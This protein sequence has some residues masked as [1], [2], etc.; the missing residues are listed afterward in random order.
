[1]Y[2]DPLWKVLEDEKHKINLWDATKKAGLD[3]DAVRADVVDILT[4]FTKKWEW[5]GKASLTKR[6]FQRKIKELANTELFY[7]VMLLHKCRE[8]PPDNPGKG[9]GLPY[10]FEKLEEVR[11]M[12][13]NHPNFKDLVEARNGKFS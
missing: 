7:K 8:T 6:G 1:M 4:E 5:V 9:G 10:F 11:Y 13:L 12:T 2:L 3:K